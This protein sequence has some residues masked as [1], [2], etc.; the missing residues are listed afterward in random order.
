MMISKTGMLKEIQI[1]L[2]KQKQKANSLLLK[3]YKL[4]FNANET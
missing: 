4:Q 3:H 2:K 1:H